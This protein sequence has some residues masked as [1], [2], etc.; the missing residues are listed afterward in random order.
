[1]HAVFDKHWNREM[2]EY[3]TWASRLGDR[4]FNSN[5]TDLSAEGRTRRRNGNVAALADV[6]AIDRELLPETEQVNYELF[7]R[8]YLD[9]IEGQQFDMDLIPID[10]RGGI[11]TQDELGD[12]VRMITV[13]DFDDWLARLDKFDTLMQ[14]TIDLMKLGM[15]KGIVPPR[16]TMQRVPAQIQKQIVDSPQDSLFYK[17]FKK[18]PATQARLGLPVQASALMPVCLSHHPTGVDCSD[19]CPSGWW[20]RVPQ[21]EEASST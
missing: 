21:L 15:E 11:Q 20:L 18:I 17:P 12:I 2:S 1:M 3:P 4:R 10:Q 13:Q 5:W 8:R 9:R 7:E 16:V 19:N 14:Q 6:R